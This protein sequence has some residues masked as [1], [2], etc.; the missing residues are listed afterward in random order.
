MKGDDK[1]IQRLNEALK[2]ELGAVNQVNIRNASRIEEWTDEHAITPLRAAVAPG[3]TVTFTNTS[4]LGHTLEAR[5][6]SW[7][8]GTIPPGGSATVT[9]RA[10]GEFEYTCADHPWMIGQII[11]E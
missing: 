11:V 1:V 7:R 2:L 6:G 8:T 3:S 10:A 5:D 4:S 9:M